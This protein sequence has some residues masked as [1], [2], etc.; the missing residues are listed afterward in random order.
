MKLNDIETP[1]STISGIGPSLA[2]A[3][4]KLNIFKV[5]DL[6]S[7]YPKSYEDRTKTIPIKDFSKVAK[8]HCFAKVLDHQWFGFGKMRTLKIIIFDGETRATLVCYNRPFMEKALPIG[9]VISV[10]APFS[11]KYDEIQTSVSDAQ[12]VAKSGELQE[13][14]GKLDPTAKILSLYHLTSGLTQNQYRKT[15]QQALKMYGNGISSE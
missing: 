6:L 10:T 14:V 9:S 5:S 15:V 4:S 13:F 11:Y 12:I 7:T 2:S 3:F 8:I 1:I